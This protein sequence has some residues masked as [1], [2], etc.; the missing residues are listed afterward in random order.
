MN[1]L[2]AAIFF[3]L[4]SPAFL[5]AQD[6]TWIPPDKAEI[7]TIVDLMYSMEFVRAEKRLAIWQGKYPHR[8]EGYFLQGMNLWVQLFVDIYNPFLDGEF[9]AKMDEVIDRCEEIEEED[10]LKTIAAFYKS[11]AI[12]FKARLYGNRENWFSAARFGIKA[13]DGIEE[14][15][16]GKYSNEDAK[17]G[18]GVY[19]YYADVIPKEYPMV[20]PL[21][22]FYP[23]G[24]RKKGLDLLREAAAGGLFTQTEAKYYLGMIYSGQEKDPFQALKYFREISTKY[25]R[26]SRFLYWRGSLAYQTGD[27]RDADSCM[28][29]M[30]ARISANQPFYFPHQLRYIY[31]IRG[32]IAESRN[33]PELA[34][35][36]YEEALKPV[37][38]EIHKETE[39]YYVY[40]MIR[41]ANLM[42]RLGFREEAEKRFRQILTIREYSNSHRRAKDGLA[43]LGIRIEDEK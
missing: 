23:K 25:P 39:N 2:L 4:L 8:P 31:Y 42:V 24:D 14:A 22:W 6:R 37:E 15:I 20:K 7:D 34:F 26:N 11:G 27:Y 40:C 32:L 3:L 28:A 43:G 12:G 29:V 5:N 1:N 16:D 36:F 17:F 30:E 10:S 33:N 21:L 38:P 35:T 19:Y 41:G 9:Q 18:A 13:L